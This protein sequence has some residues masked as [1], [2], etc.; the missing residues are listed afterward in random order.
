MLTSLQTNHKHT[1]IG[2]LKCCFRIKE[3][4]NR[5]HLKTAQRKSIWCE[6]YCISHG[7]KTSHF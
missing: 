7:L 2:A 5:T 4:C 1:H 6:M 3:S